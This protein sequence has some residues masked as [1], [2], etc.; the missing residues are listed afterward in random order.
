MI[1]HDIKQLS[2]IF[3]TSKDHIFICSHQI[4]LVSKEPNCDIQEEYRRED[5]H[6]TFEAKEIPFFPRPLSSLSLADTDRYREIRK[7][8]VVKIVTHTLS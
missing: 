5:K 1:I 3:R 4:V 8:G 6:F 2:R 7:F